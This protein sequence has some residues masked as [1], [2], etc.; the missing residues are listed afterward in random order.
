MTDQ[1][2]VSGGA[3]PAKALQ[4]RLD[5]VFT[6]DRSESVIARM[7]DAAISRYDRLPMLDVVLERVVRQ[8]GERLM[9]MMSTHVEAGLTGVEP[10]RFGSMAS[11]ISKPCLI[12]VVS[13]TDWRGECVIAVDQTLIYAMVEI[14]LGGDGPAEASP[15]AEAREPTAIE[16]RLTQR[17]FQVLCDRLSDGFA[18]LRPTGFAIQRVETAP[19]FAMIARSAAAAI[20]ARIRLDVGRRSGEMHLVIPYTT[21]EP[22]RQHLG[23]MSLGE[24]FG[25]DV[26]W[27]Q[28]LARRV[29]AAP[30]RL[31][32]GLEGAPTPLSQILE[33][34]PGDVI[35]LRAKGPEARAAVTC[36]GVLV[37]E[38][39][40]GARRGSLAVKL[41]HVPAGL[42]EDLAAAGAVPSSDTPADEAAEK[43]ASKEAAAHAA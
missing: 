40:V 30:V 39:R 26:Y 4:D 28:R 37:G 25:R 21:L 9:Q 1:P 12:A 35:A 32:A 27:D 33:W 36:Q 24:N 14:L 10:G 16:R 22:A 7:A 41:D 19:Q 6:S 11:E 8:F 34:K 43:S 29:T 3:G 38:G 31:S 18:P 15:A 5:G 23:Q 13:A 20:R 42:A 17:I 2:D